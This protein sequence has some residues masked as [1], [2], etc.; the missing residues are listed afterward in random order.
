MKCLNYSKEIGE[1]VEVL[2]GLYRKQS[3]SLARRRLRFLVLLKSGACASQ[4]LAGA[5]IG[6]KARA[7]EKLW[8]LYRSKGVAGLLEKPHSGQPP[9]LTAKAK[10]ALQK[11]LDGN[12]LQTLR[13][14]CAFVLQK[15]GIALSLSAMHHYFKAHGIKK[16]TGRP[17]NVR[18][19][20]AGEAVFK[21][22][23]FPA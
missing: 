14:A 2:Q 11:Q 17:T 21:K 3:R 12:H 9:K 4:A 22:K 13:D 18:K 8:A 23:S 10:A 1:E 19:D 15:H 5:K 16:K 6:I 20:A 7:A